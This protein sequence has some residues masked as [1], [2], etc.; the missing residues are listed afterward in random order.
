[1]L[2]K[3]IAE[4][5][6]TK[7]ADWLLF[8][9]FMLVTLAAPL[10]WLF[11]NRPAFLE[12]ENR[13]R[14]EWRSPTAQT[15]FDGS[16]GASVERWLADNLPAREAFVGIYA[17]WRYGTGRQR[18]E[19]VFFDGRGMLIEAPARL[20]GADLDRR[21]DKICDFAETTG[22]RATLLI[23]PTAGYSAKAHLPRYLWEGYH[24]D[25][26]FAAARVRLG[27]GTADGLADDST[28]DGLVGGA[29]GL[30]DL[31]DV[32][33]NSDEPLFYRTDHHWNM[34]GAYRAYAAL[35]PA[36]GFTPRAAGDYDIEPHAG[37]RGSTYSRSGLW[38][39]RG[40]EIELWRAANAVGGVSSGASG[41]ADDTSGTGAAASSGSAVQ[42]AGSAA[43]RFRVTLS[44]AAGEVSDD[45]FFTSRL[46][47]K[48]QYLVYLDGN[49]PLTVVENLSIAEGETLIVVKDSYAN[50][51][52]TLL[53]EHYKNLVLVDLRYYR[54][55]VSAL[56]KEWNAD[57]ILFVYSV[58]H[59]VN[60]AD[61]LWLR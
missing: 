18:A 14:A 9:L 56:A 35:G 11:G 17:Y 1:M 45:M 60:D 59:I 39:T 6:G 19:D 29:V 28:A 55:E 43:P 30:V 7:A 13:Y 42:N 22:L 24:D 50:S 34:R 61:L 31:R 37:F 8:A 46:A 4:R 38:L 51:L 23:P 54:R 48:D 36:L 57:D 25:A 3:M 2:M 26:V 44:D 12:Q 20:D 41:E 21:L 32:F 15:L 40:D 10:F 47:E 53:A 5:R 52:A 33:L 49:H 27:G 58:E 16:W